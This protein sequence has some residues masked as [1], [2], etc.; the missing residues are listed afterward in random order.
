[1]IGGA[2]LLAAAP[3]LPR[4]AHKAPRAI[5]MWDFSWLERRWPGA[6]YEDWDCALDGLVERGY[7]AVRIDAY[8]HLMLAGPERDRTLHFWGDY[9]WGSPGR[10]TVR[11]MPALTDFIRKCTRRGVKVALSSWYRRDDADL[12]M[13]LRD[14]IA[15]VA[16]WTATLNAVAAAGLGDQILYVDVCN[17]WPGPYWAPFLKPPLDWGQWTDPRAVAYVTP[18]LTALRTAFPE[19]PI[20]FS[21]DSDAPEDYGRIRPA[22]D[23]IEHHVWMGKDNDKAFERAI[24]A[25]TPPGEW[26]DRVA[27]AGG[28]VYAAQR[29]AWD[30]SLTGKLARLAAASRATG[31]PLV[32]TE[33]WAMV[34]LRDW[35]MLDWN[36]VRAICEVGV[37]TAARSGRWLATCSSNFCAPQVAGMWH[38]VAWHRHITHIIKTAPIDTDLR[39]A[40][41]YA[42]L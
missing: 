22:M 41:L 18:V 17:E 8:P 12:R 30:L 36:W 1:M 4:P 11:I 28:R 16:A 9:A 34:S 38:D 13:R 27:E 3:T 23:L 15:M 31:L 7:D 19:L 42:R 10:V 5:A 6:G 21:A 37:R 20:C 35:P 32:T 29:S 2:A 33:G 25:A 24:V 26:L 14:P 40:K 39:T